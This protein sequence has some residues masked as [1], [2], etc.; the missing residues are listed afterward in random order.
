[1]HTSG[2]ARKDEA[3]SLE[4]VRAEFRKWNA[5]TFLKAAVISLL[6]GLAIWSWGWG[7][8]HGVSIVN[9]HFGFPGVHPGA[10]GWAHERDTLGQSSGSLGAP[11]APA[12]LGIGNFHAGFPWAGHRSGSSD[13]AHERDTLAIFVIIAIV[14]AIAFLVFI[15]ARSSG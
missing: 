7:L 5:T 9:F 2:C 3:F 10:S 4:G 13:R 1:M 6:A 11:A 15:N 8:I 12:P 14:I